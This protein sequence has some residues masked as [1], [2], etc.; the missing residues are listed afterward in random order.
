MRAR[1]EAPAPADQTAC[2]APQMWQAWRDPTPKAKTNTQPRNAQR[3][4]RS[5]GAPVSS[6]L[7]NGM[8]C[9]STWACGCSRKI[10]NRMLRAK[11][12]DAGI[13]SRGATPN[14]CPTIS[15]AEKQGCSCSEKARTC[16]APHSAITPGL[17]Q[18]QR[19]RTSTSTVPVDLGQR[20]D[21]DVA[22]PRVRPHVVEVEVEVHLDELRASRHK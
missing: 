1:S 17:W 9:P 6:S 4:R 22:A 11:R 8:N 12:R 3:T 19:Q 14:P 18:G 20:L 2:P 7:M 5:V 21:F 13:L 16:R 10:Q 15:G